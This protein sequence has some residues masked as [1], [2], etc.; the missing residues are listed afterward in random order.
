MARVQVLALAGRHA[1]V[2]LRWGERGGGGRGRVAGVD[3]AAGRM[4]PGR[5]AVS[6]P[7]PLAVR[8]GAPAADS[9]RPHVNWFAREVMLRAG[10]AT[11]APCERVQRGGSPASVLPCTGDGVQRARANFCPARNE[12]WGTA[13]EARA[14]A[15]A[16]GKRQG[17]LRGHPGQAHAAPVV[18]R[19]PGAAHRP[20]CDQAPH[21]VRAGPRAAHL[22]SRAGVRRRVLSRGGRASSCGT[23]AQWQ[24]SVFDAKA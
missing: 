8:G 21:G 5:L 6:R 13:L 19:A 14:A 2:A 4:L 18:G 15:R 10:A 9:P 24:P 7:G 16:A 11:D 12:E 17:Q 20:A 3:L 23:S 22:A 1:Y